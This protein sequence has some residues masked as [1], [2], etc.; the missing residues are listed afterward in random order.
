[1]V[2]STWKGRRIQRKGRGGEEITGRI[3]VGQHWDNTGKGGARDGSGALGGTAQ[4]LTLIIEAVDAVD[5]GTLM[6]APQQEEVLGVLD[7]VSEQ[8]AD[9]LQRLLAPVH[10]VSQKQVIALRGEAPVLEEPQQV[11][12]LPVDVTWRGA[13]V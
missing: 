11:V 9:G 12:V 10:I 13:Q 4:A 3:S 1:M 2:G 8:Q 6:V 7:L 5:A